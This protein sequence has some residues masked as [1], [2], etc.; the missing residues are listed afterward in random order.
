MRDS[1]SRMPSR[2]QCYGMAFGERLPMVSL[3]SRR[4]SAGTADLLGEQ[5]CLKCLPQSPA[6]RIR[7]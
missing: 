7:P 1:F 2:A 4:P 6:G 5:D 3:P